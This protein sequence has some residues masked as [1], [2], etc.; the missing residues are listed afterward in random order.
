MSEQE[1]HSRETQ[2]QIMEWVNQIIDLLLEGKSNSQ[3]YDILRP[4][5]KKSDS[6]L[7]R[8][9]QRAVT[10]LKE[11]HTRETSLKR[12]L[13]IEG[14]KEDL[15]E[16][17]TQYKKNNDKNWFKIYQDIKKEL[18]TFEPDDLR[19]KTEVDTQTIN[20]TYGVVGDED[21]S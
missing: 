11:D 15:L 17:H 21:E 19:A 1:E 10:K 20:I 5:T 2:L 18:K 6:M 12:T 4:I 14:L 8:Y 3:I 16:A 7:K 9:M 13:H